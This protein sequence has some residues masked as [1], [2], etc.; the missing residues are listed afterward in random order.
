M[1]S[2]FHRRSLRA[3]ASALALLAAA[4][5]FA[6]PSTSAPATPS[7]PIVNLINDARAGKG[8]EPLQPLPASLAIANS[9][10]A[11]L[12]LRRLIANGSCDHDLQ[13]WQTFQARSAAGRLRPVSEVLGCP[14]PSGRW[15][16]KRVLSLWLKSS[17]HSTILLNR[18]RTSHA[19]CVQLS[20]AGRTGA[21]CTFWVPQ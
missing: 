12:V 7:D 8:R 4:P 2:R 3:L 18:P 15:D 16:P 14:V 6:A 17:H 21:L 19:G 11:E 9:A 1:R 13:A 10:Y 20:E 5:A